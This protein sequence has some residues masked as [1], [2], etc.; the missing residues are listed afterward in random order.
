MLLLHFGHL[1][2]LLIIDAAARPKPIQAIQVMLK[3]IDSD[4]AITAMPPS[5]EASFALLTNQFLA[6]WMGV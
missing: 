5:V 3:T 6:R 1:P 2:S 4:T